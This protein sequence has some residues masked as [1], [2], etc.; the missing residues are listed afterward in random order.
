MMHRRASTGLAAVLFVLVVSLLAYVTISYAQ[1]YQNGSMETTGVIPDNPP[2]GDNGTLVG[3]ESLNQSFQEGS[4]LH[5]F[6]VRR[7]NSRR[8]FPSNGNLSEPVHRPPPGHANSSGPLNTTFFEHRP[9]PAQSPNA[10][11][12]SIAV[13]SEPAASEAGTVA[14]G[15]SRWTKRSWL[16]ATRPG[17]GSC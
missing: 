12:A 9:G 2:P 3:N 13:S 8:A 11:G 14:R 10:S 1:A 4:A 7:I 6:E 5:A 16:S 15:G 17:T